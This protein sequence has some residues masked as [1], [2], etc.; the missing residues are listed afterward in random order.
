MKIRSILGFFL[1]LALFVS[2]AFAQRNSS[3][4][5]SRTSSAA[6][7]SPGAVESPSAVSSLVISQVYGG[8]GAT[9][10]SPTYKCDYVEIFNRSA[11]SQSLNGLALQYGASAGNFGSTSTNIFAL[12]NVSLL[13]GQHYLVQLNCGT[14]GPD[15]TVTPDVTTTN[16]QMATA[17]GKVALTNSSTA[18]GC[19][20]SATP[21]VLPDNRILDTVSYGAANN[22][23]GNSTVNNGVAI[24]NTK[25]GVRNSF[26]CGDSNNNSADFR[27]VVNPVP[28]NRLSTPTYCHT[29]V[30]MDGDHLTD[31]SITRGPSGAFTFVNNRAESQINGGA[32][33]YRDL[34]KLRRSQATNFAGAGAVSADDVE[35][36]TYN[37]ADGTHS[38]SLFGD[39][40]S[41]S[42]TPAD[43]DG[44]GRSD[45]AF[46]RPGEGETSGFYIIDS[47]TNTYHFEQMGIINDDPFVV[48]DY[49]GDGKADPATFRCPPDDQGPGQCCFFYRAS[50]NNPNR[51]ITYIFWGNGTDLTLF[52]DPGDYD[53]D[54]KYDFC[55]QTALNDG[56]GHAVFLLLRSS[57]LGADY[58]FWGLDTDY[59]EPG[60]FDGDGKNDFMVARRGNGQWQHFLLTRAALTANPGNPATSAYIFGLEDDDLVPGDYDGDGRQDLATW[61]PG[62]NP[63]DQ[64]YFIAMG[65][66]RGTTVFPWG[67]G[68]DYPNATWQVH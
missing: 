43:F 6:A 26:G 34:K 21:C 45:I 40:T 55:L 57:D 8:G 12:P 16:L 62:L 39:V 54:G 53:G 50:S 14:F 41:D 64:S 65:S 56:A 44:D 48:G 28:R 24:D 32:T 68:G 52:A 4:R 51:G 60:D 29:N 13:Q 20:A 23:E 11:T 35:W 9:S 58:I 7:T 25:G 2:A 63:G 10:G 22:G 1:I 31:Y 36:W 5:S 61:R 18:L 19:G 38:V 17:S 27:V 3:K 46:W 15:L 59:L 37:S 47:S 42:P 33:A 30:D 66:S 49:D 67:I